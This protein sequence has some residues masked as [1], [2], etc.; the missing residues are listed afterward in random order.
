M[1]FLEETFQGRVISQG[2]P[3]KWPAK[4]CDLA[5]N[6]YWFWGPAQTFVK[7]QNP[8]SFQDLKAALQ[9]YIDSVNEDPEYIRRS[10]AHILKRAKICLREEGGH[11]EHLLKKKQPAEYGDDSTDDSEDSSDDEESEGDESEGDKSEG[12]ESEDDE[13]EAEKSEDERD[14]ENGDEEITSSIEITAAED[15]DDDNDSEERDTID[16]EREETSRLN[17]MERY[18]LKKI[19]RNGPKDDRLG[20]KRL[21]TRKAPLQLAKPKRV[22]RFLADYSDSDSD[23]EISF[24]K[25]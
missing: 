2:F 16:N 10:V 13:N 7:D 11:F 12:D 1:D 9:S 25:N 8:K 20:A 21:A 14:L 3:F 4:S 5:P 17:T 23:E 6:D 22:R 19:E 15:N 24:K 18:G